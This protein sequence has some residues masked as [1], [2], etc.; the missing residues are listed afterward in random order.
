MV[1]DYSLSSYR[2]NYAKLNLNNAEESFIVYMIIRTQILGNYSNNTDYKIIFNDIGKPKGKKRKKGSLK[3]EEQV[4]YTFLDTLVD[5]CYFDK[6]TRMENNEVLE[7]LELN[8][9]SLILF[10]SMMTSSKIVDL[11]TGKLFGVNK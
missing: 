8:D 5:K 3:E 6:S 7:V 2:E 1:E 4:F 10:K 9:Y 11:M